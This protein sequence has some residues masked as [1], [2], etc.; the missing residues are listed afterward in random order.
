[1]AHEIIVYNQPDCASCRQVE[2]FL[3]KEGVAYVAKDVSVD[4][5]ALQELIDMGYMTTPVTVVDGQI[6]AGFNRKRLR[7]LLGLEPS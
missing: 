5:Q 6:V 2:D 1:M 7:V 4:E 3:D